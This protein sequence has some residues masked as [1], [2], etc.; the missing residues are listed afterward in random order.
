MCWAEPPAALQKS[1]PWF[2]PGEERRTQSCAR[3]LQEEQGNRLQLKEYFSPIYSLFLLRKMQKGAAAMQFPSQHPFLSPWVDEE[4]QQ[5]QCF[6]E[7]SDRFLQPQ[8][9]PAAKTHHVTAAVCNNLRNWF[10]YTTEP[11]DTLLLCRRRDAASSPR[12][13]GLEELRAVPAGLLR[14]PG[15]STQASCPFGDS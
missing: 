13:L 12:L 8:S 14:S 2:G 1:P 10:R 3:G 5:P 4:V 6:P 7:A 11:P 9:S 15:H